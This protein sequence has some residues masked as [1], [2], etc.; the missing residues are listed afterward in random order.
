MHTY[1]SRN[2]VWISEIRVGAVLCIC[3]ANERRLARRGV[4]EMARRRAGGAV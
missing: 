4:L 3:E 2:N 1:L